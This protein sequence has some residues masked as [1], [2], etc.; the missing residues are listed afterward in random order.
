MFI[1]DFRLLAKWVLILVSDELAADIVLVNGK[2]VTVDER[3]TIAEAVAIKHGRIVKVGTSGEVQELA[4]DN[5][6][7][8]DLNGRAVL[9]GLTDA[10]VHMIQG[11]TRAL[12]PRKLDCRDFYHP[13]IKSIGD[14][15]S[16]IG[17]HARNIPKGDWVIA[18]GSPMA[19]FRF[20]EGR[21][22]SRVDMD[23]AT[24][25]HPAFISFR[26]THHRRE[27]AWVEDS[28]DNRGDT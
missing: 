17:K 9:P 5:T 14:I 13:E 6:E 28:R 7:I 11:G 27:L 19:D 20:I 8:I 10:H 15:V 1:I 16:R 23:K 3:D 2:V 12:D 26:G 24:T 21:Y 22:P 25:D 4:G 18:I